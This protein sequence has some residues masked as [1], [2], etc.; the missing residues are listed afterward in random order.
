MMSHYLCSRRMEHM[1]RVCCTYSV[2]RWLN[3]HKSSEK[4][5]KI[6]EQEGPFSK[7]LVSAVHLHQRIHQS[8]C[9]RHWIDKVTV[10]FTSAIFTFSC[11]YGRLCPNT[12]LYPEDW[13]NNI[14]TVE[15][16]SIWTLTSS[17]HHHSGFDI[18]KII[19]I[20]LSVVSGFT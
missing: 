13:C 15:S 7:W 2:K 19:N 5:L 18:K 16:R 10:I 20:W 6:S 9:R 12:S 17:M 1:L 11:K 8:F 3:L 4:P 14:S